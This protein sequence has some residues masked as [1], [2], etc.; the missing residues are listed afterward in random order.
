MAD[1][2]Q[3]LLGYGRMVLHPA[4]KRANVLR[5]WQQA[6]ELV[7]RKLAARR[8]LQAAALQW[9]KRVVLRGRVRQMLAR[10]AVRTTTAVGTAQSM[11]QHHTDVVGAA[12]TRTAQ[13]AAPSTKRQMHLRHAARAG[14]RVM[15]LVIACEQQ[16]TLAHGAT[17]GAWQPNIGAEN[18]MHG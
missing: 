15:A 2:L 7:K 5:R 13:E 9:A 18:G 17:A 8:H 10:R 14:V 3:R 12:T 11:N 4:V 1:N 6:G 16:R